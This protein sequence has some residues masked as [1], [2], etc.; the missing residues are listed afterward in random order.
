MPRRAKAGRRR[1]KRTGN[2]GKKVS[3]NPM[4]DRASCVTSV[5]FDDLNLLTSYAT[6]FD[7]M[8]FDRALS[9]AAQFQFYRATKVEYIYEPLFNTYQEGAGGISIPYLYYSMNR[10]GAETQIA[11]KEALMRRGAVPIKFTKR[12][13]IGYKPNTLMGTVAGHQISPGSNDS[14]LHQGWSYTP[15]YDKWQSTEVLTTGSFQVA[16]AAANT[17]ITRAYARPTTYYGHDFFID[18]HA[19]DGDKFA[20]KLTARVH[21]EFKMPATPSDANSSNIAA[22]SRLFQ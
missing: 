10:K 18:Q 17:D 4:K 8:S 12:I 5:E 21:W 2:R 22:V 15:V 9:L 14:I 3:M 16:P 13:E 19:G 1:G 20:G 7:I 6:Q 11:S